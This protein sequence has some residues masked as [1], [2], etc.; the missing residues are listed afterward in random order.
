MQ[1]F[2]S[3]NPGEIFFLD[4][5][6]NMPFALSN[7]FTVSYTQP[8]SQ[9]HGIDLNFG[10]QRKEM[11][12]I[13]SRSASTAYTTSHPVYR[14]T[15]TNLLESVLS[16]G[17]GRCTWP[18]CDSEAVL[19]TQSLL[20]T[21]VYNLHVSPLACTYPGCKRKTPFGKL[22]DLERHKASIHDRVTKFRCP[23]TGC[24]RHEQGFPRKDKLRAHLKVHGPRTRSLPLTC[25]FDHC[26][27]RAQGIRRFF[28][29]KELS[30]HYDTSHGNYECALGL[31]KGSSSSF[32]VRALISHLNSGQL[33]SFQ[34]LASCY[35][36]GGAITE[37]DH[38]DLSG[39]SFPG[40]YGSHCKNCR[41][42][43]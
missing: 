13:Q 26:D 21:H 5:Q 25:K 28:A 2:P 30:T 9:P 40:W 3:T 11:T 33:I 22:A 24:P 10:P 6:A 27:Y 36:N 35:P 43:N 16:R 12:D 1:L 19:K 14:E 39:R 23:I 4:L 34:A 15:P 8:Q 38:H 29:A 20:E 7:R 17:P 41:R 32:T 42:R 31:C 37:D 18:G